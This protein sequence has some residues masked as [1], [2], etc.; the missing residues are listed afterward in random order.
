MKSFDAD[1]DPESISGHDPNLQ[2]AEDVA[3]G[4]KSMT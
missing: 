2:K 4:A 3:A 1:C